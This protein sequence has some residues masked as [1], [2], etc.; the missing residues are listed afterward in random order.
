MPPKVC[1]VVSAQKLIR[2]GEDGGGWEIE[3]PKLSI[4]LIAFAGSNLRIFALFLK[5]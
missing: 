1:G 2:A 3:P 5:R 4:S